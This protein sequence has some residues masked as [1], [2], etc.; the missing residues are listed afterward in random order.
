M[1][2][3]T[4][5]NG[6]PC[7]VQV[8]HFLAPTPSQTS[9]PPERCYEGDAGEF[10][11]AILDRRGRQAN[12][13]ERYLSPQVVSRIEEEFRIMSEAAFREYYPEPDF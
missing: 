1:I 12:W 13:L 8:T 7:Q 3:P 5:V 6:I 11:F 4:K 9:G 2:F 10:E